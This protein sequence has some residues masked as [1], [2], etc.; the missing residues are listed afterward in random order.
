MIL[1]TAGH[2]DHGKTALVH[3]LTGVDTDRLPEEK[4][5][6][7]TIALGFAPLLVPGVG[8]VGVVDVPGHEAFVRTMLAGAS[9]VDLA[10]LVVAA[11]DGVMPQTRE[12]LQILALVGVLRLIVA[13]TKADLVDADLTDLVAADVADALAPTPFAG[14]PIVPCSA[15][16]GA[17][18][19]ALR[20]AIA[21]A[22]HTIAAR[23]PDDLFRL[24]LDRA[25]SVRGAG[26]VVTGTV[27]SGSIAPADAVVVHPGA[28]ASR[29]RSVESHGAAVA[30][31]TAGHRVAIALPDLTRDALT[32]GGVVVR[33]GDAW[34]PTTTW[35]ADAALSSD[36]PAVTPRTRL[37]LHLGTV[38]VGAR[39]VG[40]PSETAPWRSHPVRVVLDHPV[41]A[42][43]GD[44]FVLRAASPVRTIGGGTV[45]DPDPRGS[46]PRPFPHASASVAERLGW[47]VDE[48][49]AFGLPL[50]ELPIRLG[51]A[52]GDAA[53]L[54]AR[55][56]HAVVL[57]DRLFGD[58]VR[59][60]LRGRLVSRVSA[61]H[62]AE[63]M[64]PGLPIDQGRTVMSA[65]AALFAHV[66]DDLVAKGKL[67]VTKG[68][69]ARAG[70]TPRADD[71]AALDA[72][73]AT[74]R[75]AGREP[76]DVAEL[77]V[78]YGV[79]TL[80]WLRLLERQKRVVAVTRDRFYE[81]ESLETLLRQLRGATEGLERATASQVRESIGLSRKF[82]IPLLEYCDAIGISRRTGD[83]RSF[84]WP[85]ESGLEGGARSTRS[86]P[87]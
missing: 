14:A 61:H 74:L 30:R 85:S 17:G 10:L 71:P 39:L 37:R 38:E 75:S 49:D 9:G 45:T 78:R 62:A 27:W 44:R 4:A 46:R 69:I 2:I 54:I 47:I 59:A 21:E 72:I 3:A 80:Q 31:G 65:H 70:F 35:R 32:H 43:A 73:V 22:A 53:R 64:S 40:I 19:E 55:P 18:L 86:A 15:R 5:R 1:G 23:D 50:E 57:A 79:D 66:L 8:T 12:H 77:S 33:A 56:R 6:G 48:A 76:P 16:T 36:A 11:D 52:P 26:T 82:L 13:L 34:R 20:A 84:H 87:D 42:R 28:L 83:L 7:I 58:D 67:T 29:V 41:I 25:F 68:I 24:P 51:I 81:R 60:A 63:P